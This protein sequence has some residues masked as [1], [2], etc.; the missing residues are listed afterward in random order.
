MS[1]TYVHH[2]NDVYT[3]HQHTQLTTIEA[4]STHSWFI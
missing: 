2:H 4:C 3:E 1:L